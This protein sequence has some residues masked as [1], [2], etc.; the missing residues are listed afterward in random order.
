MTAEG[1]TVTALLLL[2]TFVLARRFPGRPLLRR[3]P[4]VALA[5]V[6]VAKGTAPGGRRAWVEL[7][8]TGKVADA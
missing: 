8:S 2:A 7:R 4:S 5:V 3:A 1:W 6:A